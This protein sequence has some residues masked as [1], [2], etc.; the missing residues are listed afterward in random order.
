MASLMVRTLS[1]LKKD[2]VSYWIVEDYN[3]FTK[4]RTD[5]FNIFDILALDN[6]MVGIQVCGT[7]IK[8]HHN[9]IMV[10]HAKNSLCWLQNGGRIEIWAWR[11]LRKIKK[12]GKKSKISEWVP[13]IIDVLLVAGELYWEERNK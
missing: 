5:L 11:K 9:K 3:Y 1:E 2:N 10:E 8:E 13:R 7:D 12:D 6:G 4:K